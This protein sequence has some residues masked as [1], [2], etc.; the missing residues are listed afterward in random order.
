[1]I[2]IL[3]DDAVEMFRQE[4]ESMVGTAWILATTLYI[5]SSAK[6]DRV[7]LAGHFLA[8]E[9]VP[10]RLLQA[11]LYVGWGTPSVDSMYVCEPTM[12]GYYAAS[13]SGALCYVSVLRRTRLELQWLRFDRFDTVAYPAVM[14]AETYEQFFRNYRAATTAER[15]EGASARQRLLSLGQSVE[16]LR[17]V[18]DRSNVEAPSVRTESAEGTAVPII[19]T[20]W[21]R[22]NA[23]EDPWV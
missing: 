9:I 6:P 3:S 7:V 17:Q 18:M 21:D 10:E 13:L 11:G 22:L 14:R 4:P 20:A 8:Y 5:V 1:M 16:G 15:Q 23:D 12:P 2:P 19:R